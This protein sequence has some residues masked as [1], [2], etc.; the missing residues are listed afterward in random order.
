MSFYKEHDMKDMTVRKRGRVFLRG[1]DA[2]RR[3][4]AALAAAGLVFAFG[5][6]GCGV[7]GGADDVEN[8]AL[9]DIPPTEIGL[10]SGERSETD[11]ALDLIRAATGEASLS[12]LLVGNPG[13]G[14]DIQF[15][16]SGKD[17]GAEGLVRHSGA[18][19]D[20]SPAAVILDG[21]GRVVQLTG[22]PSLIDAGNNVYAPLITVGRALP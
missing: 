4:K 18:V 10:F 2:G 7:L 13:T 5:V 15:G 11:S 21:G 22:E 17:F 20:T 12:L 8:Q 6:S 16:E 14:E 3:F 19:A 1:G 9:P